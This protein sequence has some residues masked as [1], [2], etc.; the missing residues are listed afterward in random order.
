MR[1]F[2][3]GEPNRSTKVWRVARRESSSDFLAVHEKR[4]EGHRLIAI[5]HNAGDRARKF[6]FAF[7]PA[8]KAVESAM[9]GIDQR[10]KGKFDRPGSRARRVAGGNK[11]PPRSRHA[12]LDIERIHGVGAAGPEREGRPGA[13]EPVPDDQ[14]VVASTP[15]FKAQMLPETRKLEVNSLPVQSNARQQIER[16]S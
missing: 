14:R 12:G 3:F 11:I 10:L 1:R 8:S 16:V 15:E 2:E 7:V 9:V 5:E 13:D 6:L 4:R